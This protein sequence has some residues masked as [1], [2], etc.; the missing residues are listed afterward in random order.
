[1]GRV[2]NSIKLNTTEFDQS[3]KTIESAVGKLEKLRARGNKLSG[4]GAAARGRSRPGL[5][6]DTG[7]LSGLREALTSGPA[8]VRAGLA[9]SITKLV[10]GGLALAGKREN[11]DTIREIVKD[12][13]PAIAD[14]I[15]VVGQIRQ[16][17]REE[18]KRQSTQLLA[19]VEADNDRRDLE[20][21]LQDQPSL[22]R[23]A[24]RSAAKR[25]AASWEARRRRRAA[26]EKGLR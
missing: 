17:A 24:A 22:R 25:D 12:M 16:L 21:R 19:Q 9:A 6:E 4:R 7:R 2:N 3:A 1:M 15:P 26:Q 8:L 13:I 20:R 23:E 10:D 18:A 5:G 14:S 11:G